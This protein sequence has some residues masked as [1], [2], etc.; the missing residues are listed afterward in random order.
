MASSVDDDLS[1]GLLISEELVPQRQHKDSASES[2]FSDLLDPPLKL[3]TN[4][5]QCG[6]QLWPAG[7]VLAEFLIR[8]RL[9]DLRSKT[10]FV[11]P[12]R[13]NCQLFQLISGPVALSWA[14]VVDS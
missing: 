7:M 8:E 11:R 13:C 9:E 6:G 10:M 12:V 14:R 5:S 1:A 3:Q 2:L 4:Q